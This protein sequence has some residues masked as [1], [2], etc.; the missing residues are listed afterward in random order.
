MSE[1]WSSIASSPTGPDAEQDGRFLLNLEPQIRQEMEKYGLGHPKGSELV[2]IF[3]EMCNAA[4]KRLM[5]F[6]GRKLR[7]AKSLLETANRNLKLDSS[8]L[9]FLENRKTLALTYNN[10]GCLFQKQSRYQVYDLNSRWPTRQHYRE[11]LVGSPVRALHAYLLAL[12][13]PHTM[14]HTPIDAPLSARAAGRL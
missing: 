5:G 9:L 11:V 4:A 10:L 8:Y 13:G 2:I 12:V 3:A 7:L 1:L 6:E 14:D